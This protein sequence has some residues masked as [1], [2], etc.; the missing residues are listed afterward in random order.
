M[1]VYFFDSSGLVKR[2]VQEKGSDWVLS[3]TDPAR[4]NVVYVSRVA[5]VEVVSAIAR[6]HRGRF[7]SDADARM[8][9]ERFRYDLVRQY[10][11]IELR[12]DV[13]DR[14]MDVAERYGLR[15]YDAV[16]LASAIEAS[17]ACRML[18]IQLA[19][20]VSSD[21]ALNTAAGAEALAVEDP[22]ARA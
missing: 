5:G 21:E 18:K 12:P 6:L 1:R 9:L 7:L 19:A 20:L 11:V 4:G 13:A 17:N 3:A 16:Q 15:A 2:Y 10:R 22:S 14:A 8:C